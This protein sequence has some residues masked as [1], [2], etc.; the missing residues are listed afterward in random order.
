MAY[1]VTQQIQE[2]GQRGKELGLEIGVRFTLNCVS[3]CVSFLMRLCL[4]RLWKN[5]S[6]S[7]WGKGGFAW[8][9]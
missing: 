8:F 5:T 1:L 6:N 3:F 9:Y 7:E 2:K 4:M